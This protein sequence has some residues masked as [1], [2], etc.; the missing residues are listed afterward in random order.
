MIQEKFIFA[1]LDSTPT[2]A[3][4]RCKK[5]CLK[6]TNKISVISDNDGFYSSILK[7]RFRER[8]RV[9]KKVVVYKLFD[10]I[11]DIGSSLGLWLGLSA[12]SITDLAI[13]SFTV[14]KK[15]IGKG[16]KKVK[17]SKEDSMPSNYPKVEDLCS[18]EKYQ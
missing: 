3:E 2:E 14:V 11:I 7:F 1:K 9:E 4:T 18:D 8:V 16:F 6:M 15:W 12:L 13:E 10:F 17:T 5:P